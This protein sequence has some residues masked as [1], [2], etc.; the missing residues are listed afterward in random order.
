MRIIAGCARGRRLKTRK[1][2]QTRPTA[3]RVKESLFNILG[4]RLQGAFFLDIFAGN[5]G[6]GLEAVSRGA[7]KC[8]FI[9]K[10]SQCVKI[11]KENLSLCQLQARGEVLQSDALTAIKLLAQKQQQYTFI[12]LDPPYYSP[13]LAPVLA[14][15]A[16]RNLLLPTGVVIV[17]H[18]RRHTGWWQPEK[19]QIIRV[20]EYGDTRLTFF[21]PGRTV[22]E[23]REAY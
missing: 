23:N 21:V 8:V 13:V 18:H 6:V 15:L 12:F 14:L 22:E 1:G 9:E 20:K 4:N 11:I 3:D 19:W 16:E 7:E 17:E 5:G 10:N 2:S